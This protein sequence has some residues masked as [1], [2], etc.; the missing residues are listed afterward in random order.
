MKE[1]Q[2]AVSRL[3]CT[4]I[5]NIL[6][7]WSSVVSFKV[8]TIFWK[9]LR[10]DCDCVYIK[11]MIYVWQVNWTVHSLVLPEEFIERS[12][13]SQSFPRFPVM[14]CLVAEQTLS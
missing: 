5:E 11:K 8:G 9:D 2:Y 3:A 4:L 6:W 1:L 14:R 10:N 7:H 12:R 13:N